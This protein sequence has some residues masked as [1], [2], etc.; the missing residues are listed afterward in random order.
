MRKTIFFKMIIVAIISAILCCTIAT[1]IIA[2]NE[3]NN[4]EAEMIMLL[5]LMATSYNSEKSHDYALAEQYSKSANNARIVFIDKD[6]KVFVDTGMVGEPTENHYYRREVQ[7]AI[8]EGIGIDSRQSATLGKSQLY[9]AKCAD[10]GD[11]IRIS[12]N[13]RGIIDFV[14]QQL[15]IMVVAII[16]SVVICIFISKSMTNSII[17]PLKDVE[18][19]L[20]LM[21]DGDYSFEIPENKFDEINAFIF[22]YNKMRESILE[23]ICSLKKQ[24]KLSEYILENM[25]EGIILYDTNM[26]IVM[27]NTTS[28]IFL[29]SNGEVV[30]KSLHHLVHNNKI[31]TSTYDTVEKGSEYEYDISIGSRILSVSTKPFTFSPANNIK[32]I[33]G[34]LMV[35][36]DVTEKRMAE[37]MRQEFF[38][39]A[40][41]ELKTPLTAVIGFAELFENGL[42]PDDKKDE[43]MSKI[44]Y[45]SKRMSAIITDILEISQL[46]SVNSIRID[47]KSICHMKE[48]VKAVIDN[49][50]PLTVNK[51][52]SL[53]MSGE[54]FEIN[55]SNKH[56]YELVENILSNAIKYNVKDG[57]VEIALSRTDM[58]GIIICKDTGIGIPFESQ[59]R[60]F[61]R[62]Y[63]VDKGRSTKEGSTGLGLAIVKHIV[64]A[65]NGTINLT[66]R[67]GEG[68]TITIKLPLNQ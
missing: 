56:M 6:G 7:Q 2:N 19:S 34:G 13:Y 63:R 38:S 45:E 37:K 49:L 16:F 20:S 40:G 33:Q 23:N 32:D 10:N 35:L 9:A 3:K 64:N 60:V 46:E 54:D 26:N 48:I 18:K 28:Q 14:P 15:R 55:A 65:Y 68:T 39:N 17:K 1:L 61:E 67:P 36:F 57:K 50:Y 66:S 5:Q 4:K 47:E 44:I 21:T 30:G 58:Y 52:I 51:N 22:V 62:F 53:I 12:Y 59:G 8:K 25:N 11:I 42:V 43:Y 29:N 31:L 24:K 27:T 41:H